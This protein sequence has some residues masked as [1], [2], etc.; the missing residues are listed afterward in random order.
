MKITKR[1]LRRIIKEEATRLI[2]QGYQSPPPHDPKKGL[3]MDEQLSIVQE[4]EVELNEFYRERLKP[5]ISKSPEVKELLKEAIEDWAA[6]TVSA[7]DFV[8]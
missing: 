4:I 3:A 6:D 1:Q 2:E 5:I 8:K 7:L